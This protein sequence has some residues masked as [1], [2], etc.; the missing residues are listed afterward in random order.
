[1]N[2]N[3]SISFH[4]TINILLSRISQLPKVLQNYI[5]E[6]NVHHRKN[7]NKM[8]HELNSVI[9]NICDICNLSIPIT[10]FWSTDFFIIKKYNIKY[11]CCGNNNCLVDFLEKEKINKIKIDKYL[12]SNSILFN[13]KYHY[14]LFHETEFREN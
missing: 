11:F 5:Y 14:K 7:T 4:N 12:K 9:S 1:M 2:V 13:D 8:I 3:D 6:Y 10:I